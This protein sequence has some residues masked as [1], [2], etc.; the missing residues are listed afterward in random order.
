MT[1]EATPSP[2]S[3][4]LPLGRGLDDVGHVLYVVGGQHHQLLVLRE[5]VVEDSVQQA[6]PVKLWAGGGRVA[7][8]GRRHASREGL[9]ANCIFDG[10]N[11]I[12]TL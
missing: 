2:S 11:V 10:G 3:P 1:H 9:T 12:M 6:F 8:S 4:A 7:E 5:V